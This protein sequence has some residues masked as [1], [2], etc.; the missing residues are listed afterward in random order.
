MAVAA[1]IA[2]TLVIGKDDDEVRRPLRDTLP[3]ESLT[4]ALSFVEG[5]YGRKNGKPQERGHREPQ[6]HTHGGAHVT[7]A[8]SRFRRYDARMSRLALL[9]AAMAIVPAGTGFQQPAPAPNVLVI[10]ADD[11]SYPHAGA[12]GDTV[13]KTPT[14]DRVAREGTLFRNAFAAAPSCTP[15]RASLL[16][17]R[18]VHQL[19]E[20]G[21]LWGFLPSKFA[22]YPELLESA[23]YFVG[24]TRKGWGPGDFKA[25]G[26]PRNPAGNQF[27]SFA[28]FYK[29]AP[30]DKPFCFW[31]GSNDP[32][33]PYDGGSGA[34]SGMKTADV[35]VPAFLP[36]APATRSDI[37]D[38]YFAVERVDREAGEIVAMLERAGQLDNTLVVFTSDNG[39]PFPRAKANLYDGGTHVPLAIRFPSKSNAGRTID[40]FVVLTDLAPTILE[41]AGL[42]PPSEMTGRT[43]LPLLA[44]QRPPGRD[45]VFLERERHAQ[46]RRG[47]LGYPARAIRTRDFL[48]IR[49]FH[50]ERWPAGDPEMYVSVGPFGDIDG[51]P[52]KDLLLQ[53]RDDAALVRYFNLA[54]A[55]RPAE[56]LYD[57]RKD[58]QQLENVAEKPEY[59]RAKTALQRDLLTWMRETNDPRAGEN[60]EPWD[61]YPYYGPA[62]RDR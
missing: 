2:V 11:W 34:R 5:L 53:R 21:N 47:D 43:L 6:G 19:E 60:A 38:Y 31:F 61:R 17:G 8:V 45:R 42:K 22:V 32:H 49:N 33:R 12:Y 10:V 46:V 1:E 27:A 40:D 14:F 51:G 39:M 50:P 57:L 44:A 56:E 25:G 35:R 26:R 55:K 13:V 7:S 52:T 18:A 29:Q 41:A 37:L 54:T 20:G 4:A 30:K 9:A 36:D 58:P 48:Y 15:S 59:S 23:G 24:F 28:E 16:T 3:F 62:A